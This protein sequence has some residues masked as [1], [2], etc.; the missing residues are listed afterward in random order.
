[1]KPFR[2]AALLA[3]LVLVAFSMPAAAGDPNAIFWAAIANDVEIARRH[4]ADGG[5]V[6]IR[7]KHG[8]TPLMYAAERGNAALVTV[9][10]EAGAD[11][12]ATTPDGATV[13]ELAAS[14][15]IRGILKQARAAAASPKRR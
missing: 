6:D 5:D 9:L 4:V 12:A 1:M 11:P 13:I 14:D 3:S 2:H 10:L 15:D 7:D 8:R